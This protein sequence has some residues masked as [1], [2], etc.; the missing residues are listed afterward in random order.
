MSTDTLTERPAPDMPEA[1]PKTVRLGS[2]LVT[3]QIVDPEG[4]D[5]SFHLAAIGASDGPFSGQ[6]ATVSAVP[7]PKDADALARAEVLL[8]K[9]KHLTHPALVPIL[10]TGNNGTVL[11]WA[12]AMPDGVSL[13]TAPEQEPWAIGAVRDLVTSLAAGLQIAHDLG[14][15]HGA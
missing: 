11:F 13:E 3:G 7:A 10:E 9:R 14:L 8:A 5:T 6:P 1:S 2:F 15:S 12:E 4:P